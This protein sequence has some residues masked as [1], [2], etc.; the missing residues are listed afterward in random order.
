[1]LDQQGYDGDDQQH[2][3]IAELSQWNQRINAIRRMMNRALLPEDDAI[4]LGATQAEIDAAKGNYAAEF[5]LATNQL[6]ERC[7][8]V[9]TPLWQQYQIKADALARW[10]AQ[11]TIMQT[12]VTQQ[13]PALRKLYQQVMDGDA[14]ELGLAA[15]AQHQTVVQQRLTASLP[16]IRAQQDR[17]TQAI[18]GIADPQKSIESFRALHTFT[19]GLATAGPA[20]TQQLAG[21]EI[22]AASAV[23]A[24]LTNPVQGL[25]RD[26]HRQLGRSRQRMKLPTAIQDLAVTIRKHRVAIKNILQLEAQALEEQYKDVVSEPDFNQ[27]RYEAA[28]QQLTG[29]VIPE[30]DRAMQQALTE[31]RTYIEQQK[32]KL[33]RYNRQPITMA[34][35]QTDNKA[36]CT[37]GLQ[38]LTKTMEAVNNYVAAPTNE[39]LFALVAMATQYYHSGDSLPQQNLGLLLLAVAIAASPALAYSALL[40]IAIAPIAIMGAGIMYH[41][42]LTGAQKALQAIVSEPMRRAMPQ[43]NNYLCYEPLQDVGFW[44]RRKAYVVRDNVVD[45]A[46]VSRQY[47]QRAGEYINYFGQYVYYSV[48]RLR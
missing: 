29:L 33:D 36:V 2:A 45:G 21:L 48:P 16:Q 4:R 38:T 23:V 24:P 35:R 3:R 28:W 22:R 46:N 19:E 1:M 8:S 26:M 27:Q 5:D 31:L 7:N 42:R 11:T 18:A 43:R 17:F 40:T 34:T 14:Q 15:I 32:A 25:L 39:N 30:E 6:L 13:W 37:N 20:L 9:L 12:I 10:Q 41:Y 47:A 44:V